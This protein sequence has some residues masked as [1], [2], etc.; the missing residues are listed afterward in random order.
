MHT[1]LRHSFNYAH[2]AIDA[3]KENARNVNKW[4]A[5]EAEIRQFIEYTKNDM[6]A[7]KQAIDQLEAV[8]DKDS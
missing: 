2:D 7:L 3:M 8:L 4:G 6:K 1:A 5:S